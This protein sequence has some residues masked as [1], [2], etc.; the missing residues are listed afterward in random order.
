MS[1]QTGFLKKATGQS[2]SSNDPEQD[3]METTTSSITSPA[4]DPVHNNEDSDS[5]ADDEDFV[6]NER[7]EGRTILLTSY[8]YN[9]LT[10]RF[11]V[12]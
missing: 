4:D 5:D 11:V 2:G 1:G 10:V 6:P 3:K 12:I 9:P 7:N 8:F